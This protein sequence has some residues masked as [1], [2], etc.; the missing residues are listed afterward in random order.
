[1]QKRLFCLI[2]ALVMA[3]FCL[4]AMA[5]E[6]DAD[7]L[8]YSELVHWVEGYKIR[9]LAAQPLTAPVET[10][11]GY[12]FV[13]DF[14]TLYMDGPEMTAAAAVRGLVITTPT[15]A[16]PRGLTVD[17]SSEDV[18][19]AY[20]Q[21]NELLAGDRSFACLYLSDTMP[22]GAMW[23]WVQR[24]GQRVQAI[25]YA[26]HEQLST[27][28][29]GY[30]DAGLVYT[31]RDNLVI[32][33]RAYGMDERITAEDVIANIENVQQVAALGE[34]THMPVSLSGD[35]PMFER[36]DMYFA[37]V[38]YLTLTPESA[39]AALGSCREDEWMADDTGEYL[40]TMEF[41]A[42]TITFVY[43]ANKQNPVPYM[44][45]I[46]TSEMEGPRAVRIGDTLASVFNRF[47]HSD[48]TF[49]DAGVEI[50]YGAEGVAP[51][52]T[53][54]YHDT[55]VTLRYAASAGGKTVVLHMSFEMN[56]LC[57]VMLYTAD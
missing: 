11:D 42:C 47:C 33:I 35:M 53:A 19:A 37:G 15:E 24:D 2:A 21:E 55:A 7:A 3:L 27:G 12:E 5:A 41:A 34:Y 57:E 51:W 40:R 46:D 29:E 56:A 52:G 25:Q 23:G 17:S 49:T 13:Y 38:D 8:S 6:T 28:G 4:P 48:G 9:A 44:L 20:Y 10:E 32:A 1:M 18:L 16:C 50:L 54:E 36:E 39:V 14:A 43:D 31:V 30:T 45:M 26:V 22:D